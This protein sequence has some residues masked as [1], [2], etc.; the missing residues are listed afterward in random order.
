M[1]KSEPI[2]SKASPHDVATPN[3]LVT[4]V[5]DVISGPAKHERDWDRFRAL[6]LPE[7]RLIISVKTPEGT[8]HFKEYKVEDFI[9]EA[10]KSYREKG[11]W[12]QEIAE[13]TEQFGNI[14]HVFSTYESY[15]G[16]EGG[17]PVGRGIN[18]VQAIKT[19]DRWWIANLI[20]DVEQSQNPIPEHYLP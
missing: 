16:T 5:Y 9:T 19:A 17:P 8:T 1:S 14:A 4:A 6:F 3:S 10:G 15:L 13:R 11:F 18:S 7:A 2:S 20:W 12:E